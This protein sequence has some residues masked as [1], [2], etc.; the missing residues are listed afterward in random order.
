MRSL[1]RLGLA[2]GEEFLCEVMKKTR[3]LDCNNLDHLDADICLAMSINPLRQV[4]SRSAS[5]SRDSPC[6]STEVSAACRLQQESP[7]RG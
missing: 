5:C 1:V 7:L 6:V 4:S 2:T 3:G